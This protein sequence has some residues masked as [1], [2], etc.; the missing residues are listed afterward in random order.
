MT[1]RNKTSLGLTSETESGAIYFRTGNQ[2]SYKA[3]IAGSCT[4]GKKVT[5]TKLSYIVYID[6]SWYDYDDEWPLLKY[7]D[8]VYIP[9]TY[10]FANEL[11]LTASWT[12]EAG[13]SVN[14]KNYSAPSNLTNQQETTKQQP[15]PTNQTTSKKALNKGSMYFVYGLD[16][17]K[18]HIGEITSNFDSPYNILNKKNGVYAESSLDTS[19]WNTVGLYGSPNS[20][21]S[22]M[23]PDAT[24]PPAILDLD[25]NFDG[26]L[27]MNNNLNTEEYPAYTVAEII[28]MF[29]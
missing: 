16:N 21:Y 27:T 22:A 17:S 13:L 10:H 7:N 26:I 5:A 8:I 1:F 3:D 19:I 23:N 12:K 2:P 4:T 6:G 25:G 29:S 9:L 18:Q 24:Y 14:S 15:S 20:E 28:K 11:N